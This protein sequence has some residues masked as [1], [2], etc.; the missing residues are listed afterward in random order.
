MHTEQQDRI[1]FGTDGESDEQRHADHEDV[2]P[3]MDCFGQTLLPMRYCRHDRRS[4]PREQTRHQAHRNQHEDTEAEHEV[5]GL[6]V[7]PERAAPRSNIMQVDRR[8][9]QLKK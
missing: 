1:A 8:M 4:G 5:P 7:R 3:D 9:S 2:Q 6:Q